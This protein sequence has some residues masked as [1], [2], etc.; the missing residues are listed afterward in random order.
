MERHKKYTKDIKQE[1]VLK[2]LAGE[3]P[4]HELANKYGILNRNELVFGLKNVIG[5]IQ[6]LL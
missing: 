2:Y 4:K 3:G 1:I 6:N 5:E